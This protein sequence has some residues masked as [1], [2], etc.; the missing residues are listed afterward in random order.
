MTIRTAGIDPVLIAGIAED[1]H[2]RR[3]EYD[4]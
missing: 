4:L 2:S 3:I 1:C